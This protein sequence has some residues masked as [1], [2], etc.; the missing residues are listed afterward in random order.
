MKHAH[1]LGWQ[2]R[3]HWTDDKIRAHALCCVLAL[4]L[5]ALV[6]RGLAHTGLP[7]SAPA[8]GAEHSE[9]QQVVHLY[10][11]TVASSPISPSPPD[12]RGRGGP[13]MEDARRA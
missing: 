11:E 1:G 5:N 7:L 6:R 10:P 9:I 13:G 8:L 3:F 2:P 12:A 4:M